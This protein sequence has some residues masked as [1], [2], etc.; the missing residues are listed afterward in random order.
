MYLPVWKNIFCCDYDCLLI[1]HAPISR[2]DDDM[3]QDSSTS[4][5]RS[6]EIAQSDAEAHDH[7]CL[8]RV[9]IRVSCEINL[10]DSLCID[11]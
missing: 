4:L 2:D 11:I 7:G 3:S 8:R 10:C 5:R 9:V 1:Y 6:M